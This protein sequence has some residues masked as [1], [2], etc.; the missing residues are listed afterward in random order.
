MHFNY[1]MV[2]GLTFN[3]LYLQRIK[4][5]TRVYIFYFGGAVHDEA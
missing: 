3:I 1:F 5:C 4:E 2:Y